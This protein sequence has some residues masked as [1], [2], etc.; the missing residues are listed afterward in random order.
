M[1]CLPLLIF[2]TQVEGLKAK[3]IL[4][5]VLYQQSDSIVGDSP[6]NAR[7][8]DSYGFSDLETSIRFH[9]SMTASLAATDEKKFQLGT[10]KH[11]WS[12]MVRCW[13]TCE[14]T[15]DRIVQVRLLLIT[16]VIIM[17]YLIKF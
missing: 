1:D 2:S 9:V 16:I 14:P 4:A 13:N 17:Y 3:I 15:S 11:V 5:S 6:E 12:A 8:L 10:P 7:A